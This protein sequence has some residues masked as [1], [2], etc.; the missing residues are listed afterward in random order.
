MRDFHDLVRGHG[1]RAGFAGIAAESAVAAI[2][3]A[4]VRQGDEDF[5]RIGNDAGLE[6]LLEFQG[7]GEKC[8][9]FIVRAAQQQA[10]SLAR[11]RQPVAHFVEISGERIFLHPHV[12]LRSRRRQLP[13]M[14]HESGAR[15]AEPA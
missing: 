12:F 11:E 14:I 13:E 9:E 15:D 1:V 3:A 7:G 5:A 10:S 6:P 4:Q 2:V 8:R